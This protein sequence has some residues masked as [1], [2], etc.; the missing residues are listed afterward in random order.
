MK[1]QPEGHPEDELIEGLE[2]DQLFAAA[3]KPL[4]R[5]RLSR[6]AEIAL[7]GLRVFVLLIAAL[8][9]YAFVLKLRV[10]E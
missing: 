6:P 2:P 10:G 3:S 5:F 9:I 1:H 8:V 4:P 7:W